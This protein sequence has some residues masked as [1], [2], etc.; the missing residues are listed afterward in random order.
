MWVVNINEGFHFP[1]ITVGA[2]VSTNGIFMQYFQL[3]HSCFAFL[4]NPTPC[5][6]RF[7]NNLKISASPQPFPISI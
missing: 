2:R 7:A 3:K 5:E 1:S 4:S 6:E